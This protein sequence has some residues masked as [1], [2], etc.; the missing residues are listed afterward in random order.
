MIEIILTGQDRK[1]LQSL[2]DKQVKA[3]K[4]TLEFNRELATFWEVFNENHGYRSY[5]VDFPEQKVF[6]EELEDTIHRLNK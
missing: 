6:V 5:K 3:Q 4:L 2:R 1:N